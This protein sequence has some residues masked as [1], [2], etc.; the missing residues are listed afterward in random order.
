MRDLEKFLFSE[1]QDIYDAESQLVDTLPKMAEKANSPELRNAFQHHLEQTR[2]HVERVEQAF[3][4]LGEK[5]KKRTCKAMKGIIDEGELAAAEFKDNTALDAALI[6]AARFGFADAFVFLLLKQPHQLRLSLR[7]QIADFIQ[8]Q[9]STLGQPSTN[10]PPQNSNTPASA[11][12]RPRQPGFCQVAGLT[13]L[14][15]PLIWLHDVEPSENAGHPP[16]RG[17]A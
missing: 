7:R 10:N 12:H 16:A 11:R 3:S 8:K 9:C 2:H 4:T 5:P 13:S 15:A 1:L 17:P 6:G 14:C